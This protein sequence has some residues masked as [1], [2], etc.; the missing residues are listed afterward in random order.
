MHNTPWIAKQK[1]DLALVTNMFRYRFG[2]MQLPRNKAA[3]E[4]NH[5]K[6]GPVALAEVKKCFKQ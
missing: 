4:Q 1:C 3:C 2:Q 5:H 6:P